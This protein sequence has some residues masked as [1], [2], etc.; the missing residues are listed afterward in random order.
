[1][2]EVSIVMPAYNASP[3]IADAIASVQRQS[4]EDWELLITDDCSTDDTVD[5]ISRMAQDDQRIKLLKHTQNK[6]AWGARNSSIQAATGRYLAFLDSD[7]LWTPEKLERSLDFLAECK[8][9]LM[10]TAFTRFDVDP[11]VVSSSVA[12]PKSIGY[13]G[14]LGDNVIATSTVV[15]DRNVHPDIVMPESY[16]DDFACWLS[17]LKDGARAYGLNVPLTRYRKTQGSLS[18]NKFKSAGKVWYALRHEQGLN[19]PVAAFFFARYSLN[20]VLKH[21]LSSWYQLKYKS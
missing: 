14:L 6:R 20:G 5:N 13:W 2:V 9:G 1:M 12:V 21:Y 15:I 11:E 7:D 17:L 10:Y 3:T 8:T 16:Y 4:F 18:R 19:S